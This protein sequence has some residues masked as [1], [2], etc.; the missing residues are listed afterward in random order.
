MG[1]HS[2]PG[3][4]LAGWS[5]QMRTAANGPRACSRCAGGRV[6]GRGGRGRRRDG[7][8]RYGQASRGCCRLTARHGAPALGVSV[9]T[10]LGAELGVA[11]GSATAGYNRAE[12]VPRA[13]RARERRT[14]GRLRCGGR[15]RRQRARRCTELSTHVDAGGRER[16]CGRRRS[17]RGTRSGAVRLGA[18]SELNTARQTAPSHDGVDD[19]AAVVGAAV[20]GELGTAVGTPVGAAVARHTPPAASS[21]PAAQIPHT[22]LS[23][24]ASAA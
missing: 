24:P 3:W 6:R 12:S 18:V 7:A 2:V 5:A 16:T 14:R 1:W 13:G 15:D 17:R 23:T 21:K 9:G 4:A 11:V 19:G 20:G 22:L 8:G 10:G